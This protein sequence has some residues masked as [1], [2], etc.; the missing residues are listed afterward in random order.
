MCSEG[1][2]EP[3]KRICAVSELVV[4]KGKRILTSS[5]MQQP[6]GILLVGLFNFVK[7]I[8]PN[9]FESSLSKIR[10]MILL[11]TSL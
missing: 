6:P 8:T 3:Y 1:K 10:F 7:G 4:W 2:M 11:G 5:T 9:S